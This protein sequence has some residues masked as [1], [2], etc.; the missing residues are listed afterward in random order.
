MAE[1]KIDTVR[2]ME[3][4]MDDNDMYKDMAELY[5]SQF[6]PNIAQIRGEFESQ[7]WE[8]YR[9]H[10]HGLKSSSR[11]V[12]GMQ[13]GDLAERLEHAARNNDI[14]TIKAETQSLFD[15]YKATVLALQK[16]DYAAL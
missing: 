5:C 12:G 15:L 7:D 16:I 10:V 6:E 1:V 3:Y 4:S 8:N 11:T 14:D 2:G 13:L 9:I